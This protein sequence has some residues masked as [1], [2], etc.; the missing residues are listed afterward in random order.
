MK[1]I[2][3]SS[4]VDE[5]VKNTRMTYPWYATWRLG[6]LTNCHPLDR[7]IALANE[8]GFIF[9]K[10]NEEWEQVRQKVARA[11]GKGWN[12]FLRDC[13]NE[14]M[15]AR[16]LLYIFA[17]YSDWKYS[18]GSWGICVVA[19]EEGMRV[20]NT[21][22]PTQSDVFDSLGPELFENMSK[23]LLDFTI[24]LLVLC[25]DLSL[26]WRDYDRRGQGEAYRESMRENA[27][28][29]RSFNRI[30]RVLLEVDS[31]KCILDKC[32]RERLID[33]YR[34]ASD[35]LINLKTMDEFDLLLWDEDISMSIKQ[36]MDSILRDIIRRQKQVSEV[37]YRRMLEKYIASVASEPD[38]VPNE[39]FL[40]QADFLQSEEPGCL[41]GA[42]QNVEILY[43]LGI[44]EA[45]ASDCF[46]KIIQDTGGRVQARN[47]QEADRLSAMTVYY[48]AH[49][50]DAGCLERM[51]Q[52][53]EEY[54]RRL[55]D[56]N[57]AL[58]RINK[59]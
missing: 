28:T 38:N 3:E 47:E 18:V 50:P 34:F 11:W 46:K 30:I 53:L 27:K 36:E 31:R 35:D 8:S 24:D 40:K 58:E 13:Q 37:F 17:Q 49:E 1:E 12:D 9:P 15:K 48:E 39:M 14:R 32:Q 33:F 43:R 22:P 57:S 59:R 56:Y 4:E 21:F 2:I 19:N 10:E 42:G 26:L 44:A 29:I 16:A 51:K 25:Y 5:N 6:D 52:E 55:K 45:P 7:I 54:E 41:I 23:K 20:R